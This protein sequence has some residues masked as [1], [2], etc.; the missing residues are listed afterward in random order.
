MKHAAI[1]AVDLQKLILGFL[2]R[3]GETTPTGAA[4]HCG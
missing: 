2:A 3:H 1:G 4:T